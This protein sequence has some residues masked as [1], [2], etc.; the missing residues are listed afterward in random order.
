MRA[1]KECLIS[2]FESSLVIS[3]NS[4]NKMKSLLNAANL[5]KL[6]RSWRNL[7]HYQS[8]LATCL[9]HHHIFMIFSLSLALVYLWL[10]ICSPLHLTSSN[11][12]VLIKRCFSRL[13]SSLYA[14]TLN[15]TVIKVIGSDSET[16]TSFHHYHII[17]K[18]HSTSSRRRKF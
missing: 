1:I 9:H 16:S 13:N 3:Q 18:H 5:L 6:Y 12:F 14:K 15:L 17:Q 10:F 8:V 11:P 2:R 7:L 4:R